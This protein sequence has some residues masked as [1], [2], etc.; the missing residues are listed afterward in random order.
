[1]LCLQPPELLKRYYDQTQELHGLM[2][3]ILD[4]KGTPDSNPAAVKAFGQ[5]ANE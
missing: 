1:M 4:I 3:A 2:R 5:D